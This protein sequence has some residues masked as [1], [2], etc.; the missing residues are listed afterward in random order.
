M[1]LT[2]KGRYAITALL[3]IALNQTIGPVPLK[4]LAKRQAIS[5]TYLEQLFLRLRRFGIVYS[6]RG[7]KGGYLLSRD[8]QCI[9]LLE[10][11]HATG[12]PTK[13]TQCND[14][15][16][17]LYC[18][19]HCLWGDL[20]KMMQSPLKGI[21]LASLMDREDVKIVFQRLENECQ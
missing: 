21:T 19:T 10:I 1:R 16:G 3:D 17:S 12:E 2:T 20:N 15:R 4:L 11:L 18:L 8:S 6:K 7:S 9:S 13:G 14:C 5:L